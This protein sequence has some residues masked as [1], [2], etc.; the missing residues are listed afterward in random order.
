MTYFKKEVAQMAKTGIYKITNLKNNKIYI[1]QSVDI[2][3]R[4][5][6]HKYKLKKN[7]HQNI[8]LQSSFNKYGIDNFSFEIIEECNRDSLN[9]REMYW[10][11]HY[12]SNDRGFGYNVQ[13]PSDDKA[14]R[15][16][17]DTKIKLSDIQLKYSDDE[18]L[19]MIVSY[20]NKYDKIPS[21]NEFTKEYKGVISGDR[22]KVRFNGFRNAVEKSGIFSFVSN[23]EQTNGYYNRELL[24][25]FLKQWIEN[26]GRVPVQN[27]IKNDESMPSIRPYLCEF[28][29]LN[30]AI[31]LLGYKPKRKKKKIV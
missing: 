29:S 11:K 6:N 18:L 4:I 1:G 21:Q 28:G 26:N 7:I 23:V 24:L 14:Y 20:F 25:K 22:V 2:G 10:V 13:E 17:D 27:D 30:N 12:N 19:K 15:V 3:K 8:Y 5:S 31:E 16:S 9:N